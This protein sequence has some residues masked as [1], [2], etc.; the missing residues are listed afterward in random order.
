MNYIIYYHPK[1]PHIV[2]IVLSITQTGSNAFIHG[3]KLSMTLFG[4]VYVLTLSSIYFA[5]HMK[6]TA[7][8]IPI[9]H[10]LY[11][12]DLEDYF[13]KINHSFHCGLLCEYGDLLWGV[14]PDEQE[15]TDQY[16]YVCSIIFLILIIIVWINQFMESKCGGDTRC[17]HRGFLY[18]APLCLLCFYT[19]IAL[20]FLLPFMIGKENVVCAK[21]LN[22]NVTVSS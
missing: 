4:E 1:T 20:I 17:C 9:A 3:F 15:R 8:Q 18:H 7:N 16:I 6:Q 22:D 5:Y 10:E 13:A 14:S 2:L 21:D 19:I 11:I 12:V